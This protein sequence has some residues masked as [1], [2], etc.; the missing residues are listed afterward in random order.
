MDR[1]RKLELL[2]TVVGAGTAAYW[3]VILFMRHTFPFARLNGTSQ[4]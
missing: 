4:L 3:V 2:F 1:E